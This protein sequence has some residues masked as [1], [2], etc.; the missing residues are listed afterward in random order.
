MLLKAV[1]LAALFVSLSSLVACNDKPENTTSTTSSIQEHAEWENPEIFAINKQAAHASFYPYE[2]QALAKKGDINA[3]EFHLS[4]NGNWQFNWVKKPADRPQDFW[5]KDF[6]VSNWGTIEV[7]GNWER[8]GYGTQYYINKQYIFP[9]NQ[10]FIAHEHN[11]VGS[12]VKEFELPKNWQNRQVFIH[13]GAVN[14]AFY[15]WVNGE[16][17]GYSQGSKLPAEFDISS[18]LT[19]EKNRIALEVYRWSDG[20]YL[21]DQDGWSLSGIERDVYLYATPKLRIE[22]YTLVSDLI[23]NY[24][25]GVLK[26][27]VDLSL[28]ASLAK[29]QQTAEVSV[30]VKEND[31]TLFN[32]NKK[33]SEE[34][35]TQAINFAATLENIKSWSA[36]TPYLYDLEITLRDAQGK[37]SQVITQPIGFRNLKMENGLFLVNGTPVTIRGVNRVEHHATGGRTLTKESMLKDIKLMKQLN[38]NSV[39]TAHFPNDPYWYQLADQHGLY[40]MDEANIE[41]HH[42]MDV[43][44]NKKDKPA[45]QLGFKPEWQAAHLARIADM[46]ERDKNH[47]S[48]ILW[49]MG[50]EAGI[51]S[52]FEKGAAWIRENDASKR[53][54]TYGGYGDVRGHTNLDYV[55]IYTPMYDSIKELKNYA[56]KPR[57]QPMIMAEYAHAMGNS[58]GSFDEYWQTIYTHQNLQ[59]GYIWD[60]VDQT[61]LETN[62]AGQDYWAFGGDFN[63]EKTEKAGGH[64]LA[65]GLIQPDR[66]LNPHAYEVKKVYQPVTFSDFDAATGEFKLQNRYN[67]RDLSH[68][69][70]SWQLQE[71][72]VPVAAGQLNKLQA[73]AGEEITAEVDLSSYQ[74]KA[75]SEYHVTITAITTTALNAFIPANY[76]L[77][78]EQFSVQT[79][80]AQTATIIEKN[81]ELKLKQNQQHVQLSGSDFSLTF[82]K[83]TGEISNYQFQGTALIEQGLTPNFWRVRTDNDNGLL[84]NAKVDLGIWRKA[85]VEQTL[86]SITVKQ[87]NDQEVEVTTIITLA[88]QVAEYTTQYHVYSSG[89]VVVSGSINLLAKKLK[90]MPR[91]GMHLQMPASFANIEWFGRGPHENYADRKSSAAV[92]I[93]QANVAEQLHD[94]AVPQETGNKTDVRW[95]SISNAQGIGL[96]VSG[97]ELLSIAAVPLAKHDLYNVADIP[98]HS[99]DVVQGHATTLRIDWKQMGLGGQNTWG[100][101]ALKHHQLPA[102]NYQYRFSLTPFAVNSGK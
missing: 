74:Q 38:I 97:D 23:N 45:H 34:Q 92:G 55:D 51:G 56:S 50:N 95:L 5:K 30:T 47:A 59:G 73:L 17:V 49:S 48:V 10:P 89:E 32:D 85:S 79:T 9:A 26:L 54:V 7:P 78:W 43:G 57:T 99:A 70:F 68:L 67:F 3:S 84:N 102:D 87:L 69:T 91:F 36:E 31:T 64:F 61:F 16:K 83:T 90:I 28:D 41:S 8:Q 39:R 101:T 66:T 18:Y 44:D 35:L 76:Q 24:Q 42:Y 2:S 22:D 71:N 1:K 62:Q 6:D 21:E 11:P 52:S 81:S 93:Y 77:A 80:P 29:N 75:N 96:K 94:Y 4:L 86:K 100:A 37:V 13:L 53:P 58:L 27:A 88:G 63:E 98:K 15:I 40:V 60:W 72:G 20:S 33:V 19:S 82:D 12:Y 25:D 65:N 46:V 14:S